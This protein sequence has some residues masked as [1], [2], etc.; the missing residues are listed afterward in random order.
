M[1]TLKELQQKA[2]EVIETTNYGGKPSTLYEPIEYGMEQGGKR[3]R[4]LL[5]LIANDL[6][7]GELNK[8]YPAAIAIEML[9]NFTLLHDDI[10]DASPLRRGVPTVYKKYNTNK[11][12]LSGD[13][14]FACAYKHLLECDKDLAFDLVQ[15][16]TQGSIEVCEGQA[17]D[18]DFEERNDVSLEE[19]LEMIRL[20]TGVLLSTSLKLG[21][22]TANADSEILSLLDTFGNQI[23]IA[24]QIQDDMFDCWSELEVFGKMCGTDIIDKKKTF[25]YLKALEIAPEETKKELQQIYNSADLDKETKIAKVRAIYESLDMQ[26]VAQKAV[27]EY[28]EKALQALDKINVSQERKQALKDFADKIIKRNK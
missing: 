22:I 10:M 15:T 1:Y 16:L 2:I 28:N 23:G 25:L 13:T 12:I 17:Y 27:L 3:I 8:A 11:A 14:M 26:Q 18:M 4:P 20:K 9:H 19:Y 6:C 24:F 21:A 7:S 5:C